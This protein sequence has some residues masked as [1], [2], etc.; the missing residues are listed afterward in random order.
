M[1]HVQAKNLFALYTKLLAT[2]FTSE[3]LDS[4]DGFLLLEA[5]RKYIISTEKLLKSIITLWKI[6]SKLL[7]AACLNGWPKSKDSVAKFQ[8]PNLPNIDVEYDRRL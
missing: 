8:K 4:V 7:S 2:Y 3:D 1:V 6:K 5:I